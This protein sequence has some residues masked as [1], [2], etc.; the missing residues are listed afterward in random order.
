MSKKNR[1]IDKI[2]LYASTLGIEIAISIGVSA[3]IG[4]KLDKHFK[5]QPYLLI[6]FFIFGI[7][8][9]IKA[10][11]RFVRLYEKSQDEQEKEKD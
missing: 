6:L 10:V 7:G 11:L 8:A 4:M 3:F 1:K 2:S 9:A 5:T